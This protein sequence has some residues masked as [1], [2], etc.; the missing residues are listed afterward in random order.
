MATGLDSCEGQTYS[1]SERG[2]RFAQLNQYMLGIALLICM[3]VSDIINKRAVD[4]EGA[5]L[6]A[7]AFFFGIW[8]SRGS[9]VRRVYQSSVTT[10]ESH[11]DVIDAGTSARIPWPDML[12]IRIDR[13]IS[14]HRKKFYIRARGG[15][16]FT[17]LDPEHGELLERWADEVARPAGV[18]VKTRNRFYLKGEPVWTFLLIFVALTISAFARALGWF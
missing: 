9:V 2:L 17:L 18:K 13:S 14:G 15:R 7:S 1:S 8:L 11:L 5:L 3:P 12:Y 10:G 4:W 6:I 16:L